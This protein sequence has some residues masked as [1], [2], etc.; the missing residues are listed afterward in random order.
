[1]R[2]IL[3]ALGDL[4]G[5]GHR[6]RWTKQL[7]LR[8]RGRSYDQHGL[9]GRQRLVVSSDLK[10]FMANAARLFPR[11]NVRTAGVYTKTT[12]VT[13]LIKILSKP[14]LPSKLTTKDMS[15]LME[16]ETGKR[17]PW[18]IVSSN[19]LTPDFSRAL[20]AIGWR[21]VPSKG[22]GGSHFERTPLIQDQAA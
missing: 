9:C 16:A 19:V 4:I 6:L 11:A 8:G 1:M 2:P 14:N 13:L 21:Y 22:R 7:A 10:S 20:E 3:A 12:Q 5:E 15:R 17:I 18:R